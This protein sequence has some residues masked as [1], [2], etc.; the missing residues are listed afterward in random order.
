[1]IEQII[2]SNFVKYD[3]ASED[4][5]ITSTK[6]TICRKI[7]VKNRREIIYAANSYKTG[8]DRK[9]LYK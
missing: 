2:N 3:I 1:M 9:S 5:S 7:S 4:N 6:H 8:M